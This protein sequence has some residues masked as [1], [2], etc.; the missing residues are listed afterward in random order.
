ML[1]PIAAAAPAGGDLA[2]GV[3]ELVERRRGEISGS[4][5]AGRPPRPR[6]H[7]RHVTHQPLADHPPVVRAAVLVARPVTAAPASGREDRRA[8]IDWAWPPSLELREAVELSSPAF[9]FWIWSSIH[10][11]PRPAAARR[12]PPPPGRHGPR[13][14]L[15]AAGAQQPPGGGGDDAE[16][17]QLDRSIVGAGHDG[18]PRTRSGASSWHFHDVVTQIGTG[19]VEPEVREQLCGPADPAPVQLRDRGEIGGHQCRGDRVA[20]GTRPATRA[21][22]RA[23][24][25]GLALTWP[26]HEVGTSALRGEIGQPAAASRVRRPPIRPRNMYGSV[27]TK[28]LPPREAGQRRA[29]M[30]RGGSRS[31][32]GRWCR[33]Q[34]RAPPRRLRPSSSGRSRSPRGTPRPPYS[35][36][37]F[38][39]T[40]SL[41]AWPGPR[42]RVPAR[43]YPVAT[44]GR[45]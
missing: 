2:V 29:G 4:P 3:S 44:S 32:A 7:L 15:R 42:D 17:G 10:A 41:W 33:H 11:A 34:V 20:L 12:S 22:S 40:R 27:S 16:I 35:W 23:A 38:S 13:T 28:K 24:L 9:V 1:V 8:R 31:S 26:Q 21:W 36:V 6:G 37:G 18:D 30:P 19:G 25:R 14:H 43:G 45:V 39:T 5:A